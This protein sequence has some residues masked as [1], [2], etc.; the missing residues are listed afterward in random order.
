[1]CRRLSVAATARNAPFRRIPGPVAT[2]KKN[3]DFLFRPEGPIAFFVPNVFRASHVEEKPCAGGK[4][5]EARAK[6]RCRRRMN[7]MACG[8]RRAPGG[9][10]SRF[11]V[12]LRPTER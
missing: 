10:P 9:P 2:R 1:M 11:G 5:R 12:G 8:P 6:R 4:F 7:A 3:V